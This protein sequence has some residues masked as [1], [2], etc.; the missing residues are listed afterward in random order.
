[1][2]LTPNM[3]MT[4][5]TPTV[6]PGPLYATENNQAF[7]VI[8]SHDHSPGNGVPI[9]SSGININADLPFNS[10]NASLLRST[11]YNNQSAPLVLPT[12]VRSIYSV[13]GDLYWNNGIGQPVQITA[14]AALNAA[15]IGGIGGDYTTSGASVFY[16]SATLTYTFWSS[17]NTTGSIEA[18]PLTIRNNTANSFGTTINANP[19]IS[20]N[21]ALFLPAALPATTKFLT[22]DNAGNIAAVY[23]TDN[24][25]I[26]VTSNLLNVTTAGFVDNIT[27]ES[28]SNLIGVKDGSITPTKLS[29]LGQQVSASSGAIGTTSNTTFVQLNNLTVTITTSGRPIMLMIQSD[30]LGQESYLEADINASAWFRFFRSSDSVEIGQYFFQH[31]VSPA[32]TAFLPSSILTCIDVNAPAGTYTYQM[33]A[34]TLGGQTVGLTRAVL[35]A[36]EL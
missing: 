36:Y 2:A 12:D 23:D 3:G 22:L 13:G 15:S 19:T 6:T 17:A 16:T 31:L 7:T 24:T 5:P 28:T 1:M 11:L 25:T 18:G 14:G 26:T 20:A 4:L 29:A 10:F 27:I 21:Y 33:Q 35:V 34:K 30:G 32:S 9:P 8:D